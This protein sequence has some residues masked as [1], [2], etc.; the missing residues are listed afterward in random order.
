MTT[1]NTNQTTKTN[2][3]QHLTFDD[4][5]IEKIAGITATR[6]PGI[7]SLDGVPQTKR[8]KPVRQPTIYKK[9]QQTTKYKPPHLTVSFRISPSSPSRLI[10]PVATAIFCGESIPA[11]APVMFE[12]TTQYLLTPKSVAAVYCKLPNKTLA[13]V[14][15]PVK[16]VPSAPINGANNG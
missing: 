12:A 1:T 9:T 10:E 11:V 8:W 5:V 7:I 13:D 3:D 2:V 4:S 16:N 14:A 6:V 15:D